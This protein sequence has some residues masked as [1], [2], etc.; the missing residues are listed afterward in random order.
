MKSLAFA[1]LFLLVL[2]S[3]N[4]FAKNI[5][6][7][8]TG[9]TIVGAGESAVGSKYASAKIDINQVIKTIP[10]LD[11]I[12]DVHAEQL[13][14]VASQDIG[15]CDLLK[16]AK[17]VNELLAKRSV[18]GVVVTHGTDSM[19]ETAYFLNLVVKSKKPVIL[20]GAMRPSTSLSSDGSLNLFNAVALASSD[21][22]YDKGVLVMMQDKIFAARDVT[23]ASTINVAAFEATNSG[24]IGYVNYGKVEIYYSSLRAH[25]SKTEFNVKKLESLPKADIIY[26]HSSFDSSVVDYLVESGSKAIIVAGVGDGNVNKSTLEALSKAAKSGVIVVRSART[27]SGA[28]IANSEI[29]D[30]ELGFVV[31]DN[32]SAQ[33]ARILTILALTKTSDVKKIQKMFERY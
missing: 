11:A 18:H 17:R 30:D 27:G 4:S 6:V 29:N 22:A 7:V 8:A 15:N 28:V 12:A 10:N 24:A 25:T 9:G 14:Q 1:L 23:K 33:K 31:A 5:A 16:I 19:E 2:F 32:L 3:Q 21:A 13:M 20:V 26:S